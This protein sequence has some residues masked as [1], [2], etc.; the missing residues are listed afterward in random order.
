V[1]EIVCRSDDDLAKR[2]AAEH[3]IN[4]IPIQGLGVQILLVSL[5]QVAQDDHYRAS[6]SSSP[7]RP[8]STF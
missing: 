2:T 7:E 3:W 1:P 6:A 8:C 5:E 4:R